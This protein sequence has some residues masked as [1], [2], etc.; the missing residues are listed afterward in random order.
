MRKLFVIFTACF[1]L[2]SVASA[3]QKPR[4]KRRIAKPAVAVKPAAK[5]ANTGDMSGHAFTSEQF[6]FQITI[7]VAWYVADDNFENTTR[8]EGFDLS[9][10]PPATLGPIAKT[11]LDQSLKRVKVL[12]T[13]YRSSA[14]A[15]DGA[16]M[17][18]SAEDLT[19][20]PQVK[21]AVDYFDLMRKTFQSMKLPADFKYSETQAEKLGQKQFAFLDVS[22]KA[23]K[24]RMYAMVRGGHAIMFT[25]S[26]LRDNDL[27]TMRQ[28]LANGNFALK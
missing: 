17:R 24:K 8:K 11:R 5:T 7:P 21:D 25:L 26:Y 22:S 23:G 9:L 12:F 2:A 13:A 6:H 28:I 27:Q 16:I 1:C 20:V 18:V 10:K 15:K 3:Q 4:A 19:T 14:G